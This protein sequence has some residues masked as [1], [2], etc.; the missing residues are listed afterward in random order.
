MTKEERYEIAC[1]KFLGQ[2]PEIKSELESLSPQEAAIL[3]ISLEDFKKWKLSEYLNKYAEYEG[4]DVAEFI[5]S[6]AARSDA[7]QKEML[8]ERHKETAE[9]LYIGWEE[10]CELNPHIKDLS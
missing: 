2:H 9:C 4:I 8:I 6:L 3:H 5:I 10:Y 7:E 1:T